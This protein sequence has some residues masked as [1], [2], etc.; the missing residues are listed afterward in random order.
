MR[1]F[2]RTQGLR[3]ARATI[4]FTG[5]ANLGAVGSVP[6]FTITGRVYLDTI[7]VFCTTGLTEAAPTATIALGCSDDTDAMITAVNAVDID[8]NEWWTAS[9][10]A[11]GA[12][13]LAANNTTG[14]TTIPRNKLLATNVIFTV[15]AQNVTGGVLVIDAFYWPVT[16][17]GLLT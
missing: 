8:T 12:Y 11:A 13:T 10:P 9:I 17:N 4:T 14:Q 2:R 6:V 3:H 16:D 5:A 1:I 7:T 15:A